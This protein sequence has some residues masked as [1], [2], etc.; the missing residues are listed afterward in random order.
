MMLLGLAGV[1]MPVLPDMLL[2]WAGALIYGWAVGFGTW[3]P[4]L[5]ALITL[6]GIAGLVTEVVVSG[7][8]ARRAGGSVWSILGGMGLGLIGLLLFPPFG[9]LLGLILGTYLIELLRLRDPNKALR[10]SLGMG[11]GFGVSYGVRFAIGSAMVVVW[12]LW[13]IS[14]SG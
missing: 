8:G 2:I 10:A 3:G 1:F 14:M 5:F 13:V 7:A 12:V 4:W 11:V 6:L 9:M